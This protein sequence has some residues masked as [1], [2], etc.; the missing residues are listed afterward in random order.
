MRNSTG[1]RQRYSPDPARANSPSGPGASTSARSAELFAGGS[2]VS[3]PT[4]GCRA[5]RGGAAGGSR[6][7]SRRRR[8]GWRLA[9]SRQPSRSCPERRP[10]PRA[11]CGRPR[12][13]HPA[14]GVGTP[15]PWRCR[16]PGPALPRPSASSRR[17]VRSAKWKL[18]VVLEQGFQGAGDDVKLQSFAALRHVADGKAIGK[19]VLDVCRTAG[20]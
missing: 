1:R 4:A 17:A 14:G 6:G 7:R 9:G 19:V 3:V 18:A 15:R 8:P 16:R 2:R 10:M 11:A 20:R 5:R 13:G 12:P